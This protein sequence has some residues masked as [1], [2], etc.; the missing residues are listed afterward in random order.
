[1]KA[2]VDWAGYSI[3]YSRKV[4]I[5]M[6]LLCEHS[7]GSTSSITQGLSSTCNV[8]PIPFSPKVP[9]Y[10]HLLNPDCRCLSVY[11]SLTT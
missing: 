3:G 2:G 1:M 5:R 11:L 9:F 6:R 4:A 10:P 7:S 8:Y